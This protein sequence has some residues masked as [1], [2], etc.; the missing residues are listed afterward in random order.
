MPPAQGAQNPLFPSQ[1]GQDVQE[2]GLTAL[3]I[4]RLMMQGGPQEPA[5]R[6][7]P[8]SEVADVPDQAAISGLAAGG[9]VQSQATAPPVQTSQLPSAQGTQAQSSN[10]PNAFAGAAA[11]SGSGQSVT[12]DP[13]LA[14][15]GGGGAGG[16]FAAAIPLIGQGLQI[17]GG[18]GQQEQQPR[19]SLNAPSVPTP[20]ADANLLAQPQLQ[21]LILQTLLG[22]SQQGAGIPGST[23]LG[24]LI[25]G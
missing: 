21:Q 14:G 4:L 12:Q 24:S 9:G 13:T 3:Q 19:L 16:G 1:G 20:Q 23:T 8:L 22:Q 10:I 5:R 15:G 17:L 7:A 25:G 6:V 11:A 18:S 2:I